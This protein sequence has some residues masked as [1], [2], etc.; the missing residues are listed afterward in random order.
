MPQCA[1]WQFV[2]Q[3][4]VRLCLVLYTLCT[5]CQCLKWSGKETGSLPRV[6][7]C[8]WSENGE[9]CCILG[10]ILCDTGGPMWAEGV[11]K[12]PGIESCLCTHNVVYFAVV[13][14]QLR[15]ATRFH[16]GTFWGELP[17]TSEIPHPQDFFGQFHSSSKHP[18]IALITRAA[19]TQV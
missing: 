16:P 4:S 5:C 18:V 7:I 1:F 10:G 19:V 6:V 15:S 8:F 12:R 11:N 14:A 13:Q 17:Q 3:M 2:L 9:F